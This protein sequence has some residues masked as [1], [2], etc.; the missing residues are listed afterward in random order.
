MDKGHVKASILSVKKA[1]K[2]DV[3][4]SNDFRVRMIY[5]MCS[6]VC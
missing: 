4:A 2:R 5:S 6:Y 1:I 3:L